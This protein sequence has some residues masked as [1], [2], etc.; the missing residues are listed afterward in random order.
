MIFKA[1]SQ[2]S[3][4]VSSGR[5]YRVSK[6]DNPSLALIGRESDDHKGCLEGKHP[7]SDWNSTLGPSDR[8]CST[9]I[10]F[11]IKELLERLEVMSWQWSLKMIGHFHTVKKSGG[12]LRM[13]NTILTKVDSSL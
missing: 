11:L 8:M 12:S 9:E 5:P 2:Y 10:K 13:N 7:E 4:F 3:N 6:K 1:L